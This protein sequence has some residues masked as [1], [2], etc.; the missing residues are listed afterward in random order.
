MAEHESAFTDAERAE[1][2]AAHRQDSAGEAEAERRET[3]L[4]CGGL[5]AVVALVLGGVV[6]A[7]T[8]LGS[9]DDTPVA[10]TETSSVTP[11]P[12]FTATATASPTGLPLNQNRPNAPASSGIGGG[13]SAS[14]SA[15]SAGSSTGGQRQAAESPIYRNS[16]DWT[17]LEAANGVVPGAKIINRTASGACSTG[18]I[19]GKGDRRFI[20]TAGHCGDVGDEFVVPTESGAELPV[21]EMVESKW[22]GVGAADYGLIELSPA[23]RYTS[24]LPLA[25]KLAGWRTVEWLD[26]VRPQVCNLGWRSGLACGDYLEQGGGQSFEYRNIA[27]HGDSG[28]IVYAHH[29]GA[30]YAVGVTSGGSDQDATRGIAQRIDIPME[31]WG[32]TIYG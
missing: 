27:D 10:E 20:L 19:V 13:D 30:L 28:G 24:E 31:G 23:A 8:S 6:W 12:S 3:L 1:W 2:A 32:L 18:F 15:S 29:E 16:R 7:F 9:D 11:L 25:E 17:W 22:T 5:A 21:G 14:G 4:G 26:Q